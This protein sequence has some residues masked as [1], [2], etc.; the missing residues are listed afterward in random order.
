MRI[1]PALLLILLVL[2][3]LP[4]AAPRVSPVWAADQTEAEFYDAGVVDLA[5]ASA[6]PLWKAAEAA[7]KQSLFE[8]AT[9]T[10]ERV[11][12]LDPDHKKARKYLGYEKK[13]RKWVLDERDAAK[14]VRENQMPK[15]VDKSEFTKRVNEWRYE[16]LPQAEAAIASLYAKLAATCEGKGFAD[17][18]R[19]AY[20]EAIR[21]DRNCE[22]ARAALG[23]ERVGESWLTKA[24]IAARE[25]ASQ[26]EIFEEESRLDE[27]LGRKLLKVRT[28]NVVVE[29]VYSKARTSTLVETL[30]TTYTLYMT[31]AG[32]DPNEK[33][34]KTPLRGCFLEDQSDWD[35]WLEEF[36]PSRAEFF[37]GLHFY[38]ASGPIILA[39]REQQELA[40]DQA[41]TFDDNAVHA[42]AHVMNDV[43]YK[44]YRHPWIDEGMA[45]Y[46]TLRVRGTTA[47][48]C[49]REDEVEYGRAVEMFEDDHLLSEFSFRA[50]IRAVVKSGDDT[51]LRGLCSKKLH[52]L[53]LSDT[54]KACSLVSWMM[55]TDRAGGIRFLTSLRDT[56]DGAAALEAHFGKGCEAT[57]DEWRAWV[58]ATH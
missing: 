12:T 27:L 2:V 21:R 25:A 18:A 53:A 35:T 33:V 50:R 47:S 49:V 34:F 43:V 11:I 20:D 10:A 32:R 30:E 29:S 13:R 26:P 6:E 55:E 54:V 1:A 37:S 38:R 19:R 17:A 44:L 3:L 42:T 23:Y 58:L 41:A 45:Y 52:E 22:K 8:F 24:Q 46:T 48:W 57:D 51:P 4:M 40:G 14:V 9:A 31:D 28:A 5:K 56:T 7:R 39:L 16:T 15:G 36:I